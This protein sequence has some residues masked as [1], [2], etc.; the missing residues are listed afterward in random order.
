MSTFELA[1]T[2]IVNKT[3]ESK[4]KMQIAIDAFLARGRITST[5]YDELNDLLNAE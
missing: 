4:E 1:K 2:V 5:E 3:Y